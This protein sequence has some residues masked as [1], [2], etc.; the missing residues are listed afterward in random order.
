MTK[1]D[2]GVNGARLK[3]K[4]LTQLLAIAREHPLTPVE[5]WDPPYCGDIGLEIKA[6]GT[7]IYAASPIQRQAMVRLFASVLRCDDDGRHYLVTPVEKIDIAVEDA[8][9][10]AVEMHVEG[11][12]TERVLTFRT[13]VDDVVRCSKINPLSFVFEQPGNGLKPYV[14][15]RGRLKALVSRALVYDLVELAEQ[16]TINGVQV[17]GVMSSGTFF[18]LQPKAFQLS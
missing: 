15:V 1:P 2:D 12:G 4:D 18:S 14:L 6:D 8:P 10:V 11:E 5:T 16:R 17:Y 3:I 7:W 13:N 9:F